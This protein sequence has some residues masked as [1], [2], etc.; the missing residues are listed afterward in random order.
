VQLSLLGL[1]LDN[2][3]QAEYIHMT[4]ISGVPL[5]VGNDVYFFMGSD[6]TH[7]DARM[8]FNNVDKVGC[9]RNW[10]YDTTAILT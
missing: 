1:K 6:F 10:M 4:Q 9:W 3:V 5:S 7:S 8:W 2:S